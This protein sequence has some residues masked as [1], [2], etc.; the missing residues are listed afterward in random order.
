VKT[1][2]TKKHCP[3][4]WHDAIT[5]YARQASY[6]SIPR[7]EYFFRRWFKMTYDDA[8]KIGRWVL[9]RDYSRACPVR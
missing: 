9:G 5:E 7:R 6:W 2:V 8:V 3:S 4:P 1:L